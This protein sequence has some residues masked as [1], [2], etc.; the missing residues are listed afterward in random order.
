MLTHTNPSS[1]RRSLTLAI[2]A[3]AFS[4]GAAMLSAQ[5]T[6][7]APK[8]DFSSYAKT[9]FALNTD[10]AVSSSSSSSDQD[11]SSEASLTSVDPLHLNAMQYQRRRYGRPRYRGGNTNPDGSNRWMGYGGVGLAQPVGNTWHYYTPSYAFHVGFGRQFSYK[12]ALPVEF[13]W[14]NF[15][16]T[17]QVLDNQFTLYNNQINYYCSLPANAA[18]CASNGVTDYTSLDGNAHVW[19]FSVQPTYNVLNPS[20]EGFGAYVLA[21][22]GFYHKV[23]NFTTPTTGEECDYY[24]G[25]YEYQANAIVDH[26]T[27]NA[28][29]F[30][31]GIG[32]TYKVSHFSSLKLYAEAR[33]DILLNSQRTGVNVNSPVNDTTIAVA[34]EFA[35]NSNRTTYFPI[36]FGVRF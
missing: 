6:V 24:Y 15:G 16:L 12:F 36:K 14:D 9:S 13:S 18:T 11:A 26:Y 33:Y 22:A 1:L 2:A 21:G 35:P 32:F 19:S 30:D 5:T 25:C 7:T 10:Q 17:K 29:G 28:P 4:G 3:V 20:G 8:V 31:A 34:N 23:T 27:S